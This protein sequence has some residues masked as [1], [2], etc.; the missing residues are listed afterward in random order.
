MYV[1]GNQW[2]VWHSIQRAISLISRQIDS[3]PSVLQRT[4]D[5]GHSS[6]TCRSAFSWPSRLIKGKISPM[7]CQGLLSV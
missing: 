7:S 2:P 4:L 5:H 6:S 1:S 3:V